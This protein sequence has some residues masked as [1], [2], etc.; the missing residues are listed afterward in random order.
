M[1]NIEQRL[2]EIIDVYKE[3]DTVTH[4]DMLLKE[5]LKL[6][7][8]RFTEMIVALEDE[9]HIEIDMDGHDL[10]TAKTV[11]D[12]HHIIVKLISSN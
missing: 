11:N 7:S 3:T 12:L 1:T 2:L 6:D 10:R 8:L 4:L 5:D 9:F